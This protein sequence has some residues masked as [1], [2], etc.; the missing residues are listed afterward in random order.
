MNWDK[1]EPLLLNQ[2]RGMTV[3][4]LPGG[5]EW[6]REGL[7]GCCFFKAQ[8]DMREKKLGSERESVCKGT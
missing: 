2:W 3:P 5:L 6:G 4:N 1:S 8:S 7:R